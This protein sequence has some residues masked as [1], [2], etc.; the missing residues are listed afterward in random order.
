MTHLLASHHCCILGAEL[1]AQPVRTLRLHGLLELA[2]ISCHAVCLGLWWGYRLLMS[3]MVD[4][5]SVVLCRS[6]SFAVPVNIVQK[7]H[8]QCSALI[9]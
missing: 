8:Q 1:Q 6:S 7:V 9:V 5:V 4:K 2:S 3:S